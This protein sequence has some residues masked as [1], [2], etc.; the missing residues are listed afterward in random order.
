V[1]VRD[2]SG[3]RRDEAFFCTDLVVD[4][5]FILTG[6]ARRWTIEVAFHDQKQ[7]LGF[8]DP[9]NQTTQAVARTAPMAGLVY[10]LVLLWY[11]ARVQ[12]GR[13]AGWL[14]RPWYRSK[15]TPSFLDMLSAIRQDS[16]RLHFSDPSSPTPVSQNPSTLAAPP[17]QATA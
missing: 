15:T 7:F 3:R 9:Q 4:H 2:P 6:Y 13:P 17:L 5:A 11:A 12:Q 14:V 1:V 10:D 16:W 8:E